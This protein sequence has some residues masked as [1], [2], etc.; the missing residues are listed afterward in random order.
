MYT[1]LPPDFFKIAIY[2]PIETMMGF[3]N[4]HDFDNWLHSI[5]NRGYKPPPSV[6]VDPKTFMN[7]RDEARRYRRLDS[8][9]DIFPDTMMIYGIEI[10]VV[11]A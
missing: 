1:N 7:L 2:R 5:M 3:N 11:F 4:L 10:K 9:K 8:P 6:I